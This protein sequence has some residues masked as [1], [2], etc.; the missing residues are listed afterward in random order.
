MTNLEGSRVYGESW[1]DLDLTH[2]Q[3]NIGLLI[4]AEVK[5]S[6]G[7]ATANLWAAE[8]GR[9]IFP[10]TMSLLLLFLKTEF[11]FHSK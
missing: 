8:T 11:F 9:A 7:E 3:A 4:L 1:K 10:A 5:K 6:K 2:L